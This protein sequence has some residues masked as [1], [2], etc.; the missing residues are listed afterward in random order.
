MSTSTNTHDQ[1]PAQAHIV[2]PRTSPRRS[3]LR[4]L[5]D[6]VLGATAAATGVGAV[7]EARASV[8]EPLWSAGQV[9]VGSSPVEQ[10]P[11]PDIMCPMFF[12]NGHFADAFHSV[13]LS[14]LFTTGEVLGSFTYH[15]ETITAD[16]SP[17]SNNVAAAVAPGNDGTDYLL[18]GGE[19]AVDGGETGYFRGVTNI[20]VRCKYKV[21]DGDPQRLVACV[22]CVVILIR[23]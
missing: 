18:V 2:M 19:G 13:D 7:G 1:R 14:K 17:P 22:S 23:H 15:G 10:D 5:G 4:L 12:A 6:G 20:I 9:F 16:F 3:F 21:D 8:Y 11:R